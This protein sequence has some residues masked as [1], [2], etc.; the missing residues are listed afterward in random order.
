MLHKS[1]NIIKNVLIRLLIRFDGRK[2]EYWCL[3]ICIVHNGM[4][5]NV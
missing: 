4:L 3:T 1:L 2:Q 5:V